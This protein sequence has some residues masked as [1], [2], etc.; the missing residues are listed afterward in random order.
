[1]G[2][3]KCDMVFQDVWPEMLDCFIDC[4]SLLVN[5]RVIQFCSLQPS[6]HEG[7]RLFIIVGVFL[8]EDSCK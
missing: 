7:Y 1:M 8:R 3:E 5:L 2:D 4:I 6:T